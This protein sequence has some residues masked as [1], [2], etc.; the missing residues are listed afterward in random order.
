MVVRL[1]QVTELMKLPYCTVAYIQIHKRTS[2]LEYLLR[3][4]ARLFYL[5]NGLIL[6]AAYWTLLN[7]SRFGYN[8]TCFEWI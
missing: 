7:F 8:I 5:I 6:S 1:P 4:T 2:E 3:L